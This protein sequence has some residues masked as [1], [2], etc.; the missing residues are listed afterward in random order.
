[1]IQWCRYHACMWNED[2]HIDIDEEDE[3]NNCVPTLITY[4]EFTSGA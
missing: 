4:E 3:L 1:M 2:Y